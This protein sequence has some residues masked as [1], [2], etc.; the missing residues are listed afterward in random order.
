MGERKLALITQDGKIAQF[1]N[2]FFTTTTAT[3]ADLIRFVNEKHWYTYSWVQYHAPR[4]PPFLF[5]GAV[6]HDENLLVLVLEP[7]VPDTRLREVTEERHI[8]WQEL[9]KARW[10]NTT[11]NRIYELWEA[12]K[13]RTS[14]GY[15]AALGPATGL[16]MSIPI[17]QVEKMNP[18]DKRKIWRSLQQVVNTF[19]EGEGDAAAQRRLRV[20]ALPAPTSPLW[21]PG[22]RNS[23][24]LGFGAALQL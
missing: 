1:E 13:L 2:E 10:A 8:T 5:P 17:R 12:A 21:Q 18:T 24:P 11:T 19:S 4:I 16:A 3:Y 7:E 14:A 22:P 20:A 6:L 23:E 9:L 15:W